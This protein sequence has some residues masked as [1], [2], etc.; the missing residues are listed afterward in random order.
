MRSLWWV[1][2]DTIGVVFYRHNMLRVIS[3]W[4][5]NRFHNCIGKSS[6]TLANTL[7]KWALKC[8][9][10]TLAAFCRWHPGGTRSIVIW[11]QSL[12]IT[13]VLSDTS[14]SKTCSL[15]A[16]PARCNQLISDWYARFIS[17]P[18]LLFIVT[19]IITLLSIST[20]TMT[21]LFPHSKHFGN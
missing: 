1:Y 10:A 11:Y 7:R 15:S 8:L 6:S 9:I 2:A 3:V 16:M 12:I 20:G 21:Y 14:L 17:S 13:F 19:I 18:C 4:A 5:N